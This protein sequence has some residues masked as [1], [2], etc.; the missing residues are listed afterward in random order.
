MRW[1]LKRHYKLLFYLESVRTMINLQHNVK[2]V[3]KFYWE[4]MFRNNILYKNSQLKF[5]I[6]RELNFEDDA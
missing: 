3:T 4:G 5:I 2:R 6:Y 1:F